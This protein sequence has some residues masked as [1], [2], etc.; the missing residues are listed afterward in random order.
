MSTNTIEA[1]SLFSGAGGMDC[2]FE[3]AGF[4]IIWAN[5]CDRDSVATH[6]MNFNADVMCGDIREIKSSDIPF[7]PVI[8]GGFPCQGFSAAGPRLV[9]DKR[10]FLYL[11]FV[12]ILEDKQPYAFVAENVKGL[13]TLDHG[14][15]IRAMIGD[16]A[17]K[18]YDVV[19]RLFNVADYGVPQMRE[20]V[21]LVG[22]RRDLDMQFA[23]PV[24]ICNA[25]SRV[26]LRDRL[27]GL[28]AP[29]PSD[30]CDQPYSSR[31]MSRNRKRSWDD[32]SYTIPAMAKQV[33][34]HPSSPDMVRIHKDL[35]QFGDD[36]VTRRFAWWEAA[37]VQSF[38]QTFKFAGN[39]ISR[40]RQIG[41][42]VPPVF[43]RAIATQLRDCLLGS[44]CCEEERKVI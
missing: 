14:T 26:T 1:I 27:Y 6:R 31:Y 33:P 3:Q 20:R 36:G 37:I 39:L 9:T 28:P 40:Y 10:N 38:P 30:V 2:G 13:L 44:T 19:A 8:I 29:D 43:A 41:N 25:D 23:F 4:D 24:S 17:D 16:F 15:V 32:I 21:I 42:A 11:E 5:D 35:W 22:I 12:R 34:L 18:G 7:A